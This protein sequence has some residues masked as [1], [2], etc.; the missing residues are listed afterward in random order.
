MNRFHQLCQQQL[1]Y[2]MGL[3]KLQDD[4]LYGRRCLYGGETPYAPTDMQMGCVPI[5]ITNMFER[6]G[7][8]YIQGENFS[9]YCEVTVDGNLLKT[10]YICGTL[11]KLEEDPGV[12]TV[13]DLYISVVDTHHEILS[14]TE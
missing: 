6:G 1:T 4:V 7:V 8:W 12:L 11:L 5:R 3:R 9:P 13:D 10:D 2:R 14:D